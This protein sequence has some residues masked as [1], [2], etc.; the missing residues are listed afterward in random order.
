MSKHKSNRRD[1][2]TGKSAAEAMTDAVRSALPDDDLACRAEGAAGNAYLVHVTRR[3]MACE[4][5]IC[6]NAGQYP[7]DTQRALEALDLVDSLEDQMSV[8]RETS[9]VCRINR[10]AATRPVEVEPGLFELLRL[11]MQV[12]RQTDGAFDVTSAPL[13]EV[14]GFA[15]RA[16]A[17]PDDQQ[18][19]ETLGRVGGQLVELDA[20]QKTIRFRQPGVQLNL[21]SIGKGYALDRCAEKLRQAGV[22]DFLIHGGGSSVLA[23]GRRAATANESPA[24]ATPGWTVGILHPLR[25]DRRLGEIRLRDRALATSGSRAQSFVHEGRRYSHILDPRTGRPAE[26]VLSATVIAPT[27]ALADALSTAFYVM[28]PQ[29]SLEYCRRRPQL[30]A[31]LACPVRHSGGFQLR[32]AGLAEGELK[33]LT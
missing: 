28:G 2:L 6:L 32:T 11:A 25:P 8:F 13:W 21:G 30:A 27:A 24:D 1:F 19:A 9:E 10:T 14:W 17:V 3:A 23:A 18:L 22:G 20:E 15:R 31:V 29:A 7:H 16:G 33:M 12:Y 5:E 26:G 4:F